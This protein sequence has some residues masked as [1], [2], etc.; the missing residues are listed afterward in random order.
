VF[1]PLRQEIVGAHRHQVDEAVETVADLAVLPRESEQVREAAEVTPRGIDR[2][3]EQEPADDGRG[4]VEP[5]VRTRD[6][7][8][9]RGAKSGRTP[10]PY[11]ERRR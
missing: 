3:L 4:F 7:P 11:G 10:R 2:R 8:R 5:G 6:T 1:E 9:R